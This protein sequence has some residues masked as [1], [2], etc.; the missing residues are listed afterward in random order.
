[1]Q[2]RSDHEIGLN[3]V[4]GG[5]VAGI[6]EVAFYGEAE[7]LSFSHVAEDRRIFAVGAL[8]AVELLDGREPGRYTFADLLFEGTDGEDGR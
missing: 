2:P 4:R 3:S 7:Q 5:T 6:H 1:M 8:H